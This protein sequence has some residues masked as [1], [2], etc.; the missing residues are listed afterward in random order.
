MVAQLRAPVTGESF[1]RIA[2]TDVLTAAQIAQ[3][4]RADRQVHSSVSRPARYVACDSITSRIRAASSTT[5]SAAHIPKP[6]C[7]F[8][9]STHCPN[10]ERL[11]LS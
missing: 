5:E 8:T 1:S 7:A 10:A 9:A 6:P 2:G 11:T 4:N 3:F